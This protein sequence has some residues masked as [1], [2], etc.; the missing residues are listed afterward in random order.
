MFYYL[1]IH[2]FLKKI[3]KFNFKYFL[4]FE[5]FIILLVPHFVWLYNND[6]IT[7]FYGLKRTGLE[8]TES[9]NHLKYPIIFLIKQ[10]GIL[11]PFFFMTWLLVE[12]IKIEKNLKDKKLLFLIF[13]NFLPIILMIITSILL[14]SKTRTMWMTPFY[15]FGVLFVYLFQSVINFKKLNPFLFFYILFFINSLFICINFTNR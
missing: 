5:I 15:L 13:V 7:I 3:K 9:I 4:I 14:G 1:L 12:K 6:F 2:I 10:I 11:I 8:V